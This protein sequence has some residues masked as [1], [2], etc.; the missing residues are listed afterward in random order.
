MDIYY[1]SIY[2]HALEL[3]YVIINE[4]LNINIE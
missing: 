3:N 4:M 1:K 2:V